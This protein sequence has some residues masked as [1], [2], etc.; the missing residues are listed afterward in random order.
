[1]RFGTFQNQILHITHNILYLYGYYIYIYIYT[2]VRIVTI[3]FIVHYSRYKKENQIRSKEIEQR[4]ESQNTHTKQGHMTLI[5][6]INIKL[7]SS[8]SGLE[9]YIC[10]VHIILFYIFIHTVYI[11]GWFE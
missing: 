10:Y 11:T 1:M 5:Y 3:T 8:L 2:Y 7:P 4:K 6:C 9:K